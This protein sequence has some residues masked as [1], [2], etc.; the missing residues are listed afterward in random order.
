MKEE[1]I[2]KNQEEMVKFAA[3]LAKVSNKGDI[4]GLKGTLGA[5][6]TFFASAFINA[7]SKK[8]V[9]VLSPTFNLVY[10]YNTDM[11]EVYHFDLYRVKSEDELYNIGIEDALI[12]GISLI[13]WP[14]IAKNFFKDSKQYKEIEIKI[15]KSREERLALL[16]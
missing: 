12:N 13:E 4:I 2:I 10:N 1:I 3:K 6:K 9:D 16:T 5:G 7:L 11:G 8:E 15:G 14:E